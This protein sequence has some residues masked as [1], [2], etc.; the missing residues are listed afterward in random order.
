MIYSNIALDLKRFQNSGVRN[1]GDHLRQRK[2]FFC[3]L[4]NLFRPDFVWR[5]TLSWKHCRIGRRTELKQTRH[6]SFFHK[7]FFLYIMFD[8]WIWLFECPFLRLKKLY[9]CI[10]W[11]VCR[12]FCL[13]CF[14]FFLCVFITMCI[15]IIYELIPCYWK[16]QSIVGPAYCCCLI[17]SAFLCWSSWYII[18][19]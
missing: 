2:K 4:E 8:T 16:N 5:K 13:N 6:H 10:F 14:F 11:R 19:C 12:N 3:L 1:T 9:F 18:G 7:L 17:I 15:M